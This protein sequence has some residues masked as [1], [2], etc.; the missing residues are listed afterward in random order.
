MPPQESPSSGDQ[1]QQRVLTGSL[2][3]GL[4]GAAVWGGR[5]VWAALQPEV[6]AF[7]PP[8]HRPRPRGA[9]HARLLTA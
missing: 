3:L 9:G 8:R 5:G 6:L 2:R 7:T 1:A 4:L